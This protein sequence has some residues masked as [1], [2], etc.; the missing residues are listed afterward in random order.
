[1]VFRKASFRKAGPSLR[2]RAFS[3]DF[4]FSLPLARPRRLPIPILSNVLQIATQVKGASPVKVPLAEALDHGRNEKISRFRFYLE[5]PVRR[6]EIE[7]HLRGKEGGKRRVFLTNPDCRKLLEKGARRATVELDA[8][9][10]FFL[11]KIE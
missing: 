7:P 8:G 3:L 10:D 11:S 1:M 2:L 5:A 4:Y 9:G 6:V